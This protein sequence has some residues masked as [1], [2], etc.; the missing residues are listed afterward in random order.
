VSWDSVTGK[1][2]SAFGTTAGTFAEGN[3]SRLAD[4]RT[5]TAHTHPLAELTG[6]TPAAIGAIASDPTGVTGATAISNAM[7]LTQAQYNAIGT[8]NSSTLYVIIP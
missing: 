6:I 3:D 7:F 8:K 2:A 5:P 1:P 4:S